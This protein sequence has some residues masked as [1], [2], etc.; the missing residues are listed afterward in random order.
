VPAAPSFESR[1]PYYKRMLS[2][3]KTSPRWRA[4]ID[5]WARRIIARRAD[6]KALEASLGIPWEW[7]GAIHMRESGCRFDRHMHNGDSLQARTWQVPAGRPRTGRP[8]FT[9]VESALDAFRMKGLQNIKDWSPERQLYEAER[10]NGWGYAWRGMVSP[11]LW[12]G[13]TLYIRGKY[14][15][16]GVLSASAVDQQLGVVPVIWRIRELMKEGSAERRSSK[17]RLIQRLKKAIEGVWTTIT[18]Y[19]T[20]DYLGVAKEWIEASKE[21]VNPSVLLTIAGAGIVLWVTLRYIET[22]SLEDLRDDRWVP[23]GEES[24]EDIPEADNSKY[25]EDGMEEPPHDEHD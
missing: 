21:L 9:F 14:I 19:F 23:S 20:L 5:L 24:A 13:T 12:S 7:I 18:S 25:T 22:R 11:Y 16:D 2:I 15:A 8:P 6:Y 1:A 4:Q 10:Y 3:M 17:L